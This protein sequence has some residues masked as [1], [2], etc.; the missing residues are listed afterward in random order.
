MIE[1][2]LNEFREMQL[3]LA[4]D[5]AAWGSLGYDGLDDKINT[6]F[7]AICAHTP[8]DLQEAVMVMQFFLDR[9]DEDHLGDNHRLITLLRG[10]V[11]SWT[12]R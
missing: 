12:S 6:M 4:D 11:G 1:S 3:R 10:I 8:C 7:N 2:L 5:A 9:I